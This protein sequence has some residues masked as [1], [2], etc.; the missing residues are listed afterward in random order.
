MHVKK[1]YWLDGQLFYTD[2]VGELSILPTDITTGPF[3]YGA[4]QVIIPFI[5]PVKCS[6]D[7]QL[8]IKFV[9][10]V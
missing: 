9:E 5:G 2:Y 1:E 3:N 4:Y 8:V 6:Q 7:S 10:I